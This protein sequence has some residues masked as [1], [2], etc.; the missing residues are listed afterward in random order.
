MNTLIFF[1]HLALLVPVLEDIETNDSTPL[2]QPIRFS[3]R[4][5][6]ELGLECTACHVLA[7]AEERASLPEISICM[8]CHS[9][10]AKES[11]ELDKLLKFSD[12]KEPIPWVPVY[13]LPFYVFFNHSIHTKA[14]QSCQ[15]CHGPVHDREGLWAEGDI[16]MSGCIACH[17][18]KNAA[19]ECNICHELN[20]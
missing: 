15:S 11:A 1:I 16:S 18:K 9:S 10:L 6:T 5:H 8:N 12:S 14:D 3:H 7:E 4:F 13:R 19:L 20:Q 17:Q 2:D